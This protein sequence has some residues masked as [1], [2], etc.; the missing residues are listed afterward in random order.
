MQTNHIRKVSFDLEYL[1]NG[2]FAFKMSQKQLRQY[3]W[4]FGEKKI[5][6]DQL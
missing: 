1:E 4:D 3:R 5:D 6:L 2:L